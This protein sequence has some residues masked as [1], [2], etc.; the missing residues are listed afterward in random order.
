ML[1]CSRFG[2]AAARHGVEGEIEK[3]S[4]AAVDRKCVSALRAAH[5]SA[6]CLFVCLFVCLKC[7]CLKCVARCARWPFVVCVFVWVFV[8]VFARC[9]LAA[10]YPE[11]VVGC[12]RCGA[13]RYIDGIT[14]LDKAL[15]I[16]TSGTTGL[17]KVTP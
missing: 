1:G 15:L 16:Y 3:A 13:G 7:I 11:L 10:C 4:A 9:Q 12:A 17:P 14:M 8:C 2:D 5:G 6:G